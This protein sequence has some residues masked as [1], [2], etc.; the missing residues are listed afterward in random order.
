[1]TDA[2][3]DRPALPERSDPPFELADRPI[4]EAFLDWHRATVHHKVAGLSDEDAWRRLVPSLTTPAG[5][6]KHL[7]YVEQSWFR[8][9]LAGE[10][11]LHV[12]YGEDRPDGDFE[13]DDGDTLAALLARYDEQCERSREIAAA[14]ELDQVGAALHRSGRPVT[15]RWVLVHLIEETARHNG[16]LDV[17]RELIDG[18]T[19]E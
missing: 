8:R 19:G 2:P 10:Q 17:L 9:T 5:I 16:H 12:P 1:V 11:G 7:G 18:A 15:L 3:L 6:V 13:R 4:L 14:M